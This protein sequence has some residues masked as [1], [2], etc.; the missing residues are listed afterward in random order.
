MNVEFPT[1]DPRGHVRIRIRI[2]NIS[3]SGGSSRSRH[4]NKSLHN[5]RKHMLHLK[6]LT[7]SALESSLK[8]G[9]VPRRRDNRWLKAP[10]R[11]SENRGIRPN[12]RASGPNMSRRALLSRH[13]IRF[14][15]LS[16]R[17]RRRGLP[18]LPKKSLNI[19]SR[20]SRDPDSRSA[21]TNL[22][23]GPRSLLSE[24]KSLKIVNLD[25]RRGRGRTLPDGTFNVD[26]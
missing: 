15:S 1:V 17:L 12:R 11:R 9:I 2:R 26:S 25:P 18:D 5:L 20:G 10:R 6:K 21:R 3:C 8:S 13:G 14:K 16:R 22:R 7:L 4:R 24:S 19:R 23:F